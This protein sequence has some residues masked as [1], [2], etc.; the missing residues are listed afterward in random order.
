[1][2]DFMTAVK[3]V[4]KTNDEP[5]DPILT[6][7][8]TQAV[9]DEK[10]EP[11]PTAGVDD[12]EK[13]TFA[14]ITSPEDALQYLRSQPDADGLIRVLRR[15]STRH[16][17]SDNF[18]LHAP[19]PLQAQIINT[20]VTSVVPTFWSAFDKND[21]LLLLACLR[22]AA[23]AN[24][25][26]AR[27][28]LLC[29]DLS[30]SRPEDA[31]YEELAVIL[32]AINQVFKPD[33]IALVVWS[34]LAEE[35]DNEVKRQ[36]AW[37]DF[38][39]LIASGKLVT[40]VARTED[41]L[42]TK[43][44]ISQTTSSFSSGAETSAWLGR[45]VAAFVQQSGNESLD[46]P[47]AC[48]ASG[49]L[50][51]KSFGLGYALSLAKAFFKAL[52]L[53]EPGDEAFDGIDTLLRVLPTHT[54]R[55]LLETTLKW[56]SE[57]T[58]DISASNTSSHTSNVQVEGISSLISV[59]LRSDTFM[60]QHLVQFLGDPVAATLTNDT[61]RACIAVLAKDATNELEILLERLMSTF[62]EKVFIDHAPIVQQEGIAQTLLL[63]A[64]H[65]HRITPMALLMTA[66][67]SGHMQGVSNRLHSSNQRA[68]WLGMVVGVS[69]SSLVDKADS[70]L[71]FGT[72]EM[73]TEEAKWYQSLVKIEDKIGNLGDLR[74][75]L[76]TRKSLARAHRKIPIRSEPQKLPMINGKQAFG[77]PKPP[78]PVQTEVIGDKVTEIEDDEEDE[79][80][81]LKPYAKPDS[82]P[83]DSDEDATLV[84]RKK[85]RPPVYIRDLMRM[86]KEAQDHDKFQMAINHAPGLIRRKANFGGEVKDHAEELALMLCDLRDPFETEGFDELKLQALIAILLTDVKTMSPWLSKQAFAGEY[87]LSQRCVMLSAI[88]LGGR[89]LAG[90]KEDDLNPAPPSSTTS[91]PSKRLPDHLHAIYSPTNSSVKRL[92]SA[93]KNVEHQL[94]KPLALSAADKTTSHLDAVKVRTFSSRM[95]V[96]RTKRKPTANQLAKTLGE[97][98][99]FPLLSRYQQEVAAYGSGSVFVSAPFVLVTFLKTL[100][101]L[102]HA[103]GPA[104]LNL[105]E[106][107]TAFWDLLLSLRMQAISD[108]SVLESVLFSLLT[109]LE[110]NV[111][112]RQRVV[113]ETPK[114]LMETQQW[115]ELVFEKTGGGSLVTEGS[116]EEARVRTL[117][118]GVLMKTK[119]IIEAYQKQ[120]IENTYG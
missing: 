118:A 83:E 22:N 67:S 35:V 55:Q 74:K 60:L 13:K 106:I 80:D 46:H 87:S 90:Y 59:L 9:Q 57:A 116:D 104:T 38:V 89:E 62:G 51:S 75:L 79:D 32:S 26:V 34:G 12:A 68:R 42:K 107:T 94:I 25:L 1:M 61:R 96:E 54:K 97:S 10:P 27:A 77:P 4:H 93:S 39:G 113:Q 16:G 47:D 98:F 23:G 19:G 21:K 37:K 84:N 53:Q 120:L 45:N 110:I 70:L 91:F 69:L 14:S 18:D 2:A 3:T 71:S 108:I 64:G 48:S 49:L 43:E 78:V 95:E 119:E 41:T 5:R 17:L 73:S 114:Q 102:F 86:L 105:A 101:L 52:L 100:A 20:I 66:R 117:A 36:L 81:D 65:I 50:L 99:F 40:T 58:D 82:D 111:D 103:A 11:K 31:N 15:L 109:L 7:I 115:V 29:D 28:K 44:S 85:P 56:L 63:A 8:S 88:G 92:E 72:D 76:E 112:S 33:D 30:R 6:P 24:A